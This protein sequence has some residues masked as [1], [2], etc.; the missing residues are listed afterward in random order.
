MA[1]KLIISE[2]IIIAFSLFVFFASSLN[3]SAQAAST[4]TSVVIQPSKVEI[5]ASPNQ[6]LSRSFSVINRSNFNVSLKLIVKDYKQISEDGRLEFYDA[7][8]EPATSWLVPQYLQ[9]SLKP[10]ET[11]DVGFVVSVPKD[12]SGGG[13]YGSILFQSAGSASNVV[14]SNFGE[15]V[16]LTVTG[17]G[18]KTNAIAQSMNFW[19]GGLQQGN[20]VDFNFKMQ[21]TG[22]T[23]FDAQGKLILRDWMGKE[24]GN[25][26]VGQLTI[27]PKTSRLFKWRWNGTPSAGIFQADVMLSDPSVSQKLKLVDSARFVIFP[28]PIALAVLFVGI[29]VFAVI[30]YRKKISIKNLSNW[31]PKAP[32]KEVKIK[33][34]DL[35]ENMGSFIP[36]AIKKISL[37]EMF[38]WPDSK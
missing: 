23:H 9:I 35:E 16:L 33:I 37:K 2:K 38:R 17:S 13:H 22:N 32:K 36:G 19:T 7:K 27:Y 25:F 10:L 15:L 26:D 6:K 18:I 29:I 24:I 4:D 8:T 31:M 20:P 1:K 21:N 28:W 11:K 34:R 30:R 12:F 5:T 3:S 14:T